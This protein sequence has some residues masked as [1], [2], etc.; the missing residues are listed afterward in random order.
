[1]MQ[2][3]W[4][5]KF[6]QLLGPMLALLGVDLDWGWLQDYC[7]PLLWPDMTLLY[8]IATIMSFNM[9]VANSVH[10]GADLPDLI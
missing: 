1:M 10:I 2:Y 4:I 3:F 7:G 9:I 5:Q 6:R 8:P